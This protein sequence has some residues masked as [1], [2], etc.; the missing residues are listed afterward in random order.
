MAQ[1][2]NPIVRTFNR[3][4]AVLVSSLG[5]TRQQVHPAGGAPVRP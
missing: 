1:A 2:Y 3:L 5:V 4:R